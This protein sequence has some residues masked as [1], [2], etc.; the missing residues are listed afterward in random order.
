MKTKQFTLLQLFAIVD[1]RLTTMDDVYN[2][3]NWVAGE[4]L[5]TIGL[6]VF[7]EHLH[8]NIPEWFKEVKI[9]LD[10]IEKKCGTNDFVTV[11][12]YI[13]KYENIIYEIPQLN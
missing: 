8:K 13:T 2:V 7:N 4:E 6:V 12:D 1:G 10:D 9:K 5:P 3:L 11:I